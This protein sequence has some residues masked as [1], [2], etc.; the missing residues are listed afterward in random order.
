M[1]RFTPEG[2]KPT[3]EREEV[4]KLSLQ[5]TLDPNSFD[6][7]NLDE[8]EMN[9]SYYSVPFARSEVHQDNLLQ[10]TI[11]ELG[12]GFAQGFTANLIPDSVL[13]TPERGDNVANI[14]RQLGSLAGFM[15]Y[16]PGGKYI[17]ILNKLRGASLPLKAAT[18][19]Q[20]A[21]SKVANPF[22]RQASKETRDFLSGNVIADVSAG[23]FQMGVA[24]A[25]SG[26]WTEGVTTILK[27]AGYGAMYGGVARGIGNMTG[28]GKKIQVNQLNAATG[29]PQLSKLADGQKFDL[30][31]R[32]LAN[33]TF[34]ALSARM[35][36][37]TTPEQV[38]NFVM[39]GFLGWKDLPFS[40][41][42][43]QEFIWK[44]IQ[45]KNIE[46]P[47]LHPE[48]DLHSKEMQSVIKKD[49]EAYF[50]PKESIS[51]IAKLIYASGKDG[52]GILSEEDFF[53]SIGKKFGVDF[54]VGPDGVP[55]QKITKEMVK[56]YVNDYT[57]NGSYKDDDDLDMHIADIENLVGGGDRVVSWVGQTFKPP[58]ELEKINISADLYRMWTDNYESGTDG[59]RPKIGA[60]NAIY[61]HIRS[62]YNIKLDEEGKGWWRRLGEEQRSRV[63]VPQLT[64][65]NGKPSFLGGNVNALGNKKD[66]HFQRPIIGDILFKQYEKAGDK[67]FFTYLDHV[68]YEGKE[69]KLTEMEDAIFR[70]L[71]NKDEENLLATKELRENASFIH[72]KNLKN[73]EEYM[74]SQ[75]YYFVG[76][77][78]DKNAMY[79]VQKHPFIT[80]NKNSSGI[81]TRQVLRALREAYTN[82]NGVLKTKDL[83]DFIAKYTDNSRISKES[84]ASNILYDLT[85]NGFDVRE[86]GKG[87]NTFS[88]D[89]RE[90]LKQMQQSDFLDSP[91]KYNKRA[92]IWFNTGISADANNVSSL[93]T[94]VKAVNGNLRYKIFNDDK[95]KNLEGRGDTQEEFSDGAILGLKD[96][97]KALNLDKGMP[98]SGNVNKS[99]IV[100][101]N[102]KEG[103][104]LGK[105]MIHEPSAKKSAEME[106]DGVHFLMPK[107]AV[108]QM[109]LREF[110]KIYELPIE[111]LR[112]TMS[113][114]T[115]SKFIKPQNLPKQMMT[116]LSAFD[117]G[118]DNSALFKKMYDEFSGQGSIGTETGIKIA[119]D[120]L[121]DNSDLNTNRLLDNI[122]EVPIPTLFKIIRNPAQ[123]KASAGIMKKILKINDEFYRNSAEESE[124]SRGE[125][126]K[127]RLVAVEFDTIIDRII[128]IYPK[129]STGSF[130]HKFI[131][132]FR[133]VA[134]RNYAVHTYTRPKLKGSVVARI[135]P[136]D[137]GMKGKLDDIN[138][139]SKQI[140]YL[141]NGFKKTKIYDDRFENGVITLENLLKKT[142][143]TTIDKD[144]LKDYEE[145]IRAVTMRVPMDSIS[146]ANVLKLAGFT[147]IDGYGVLMHPRVMRALGGADLDGDKAFVFFG[148]KGGMKKEYK[149]MY[150]DARDEFFIKGEEQHNKNKED[151]L[152]GK[153]LRELFTNTDKDFLKEAEDPVNYFTSKWR[154][155]MSSSASKGRDILGVAVNNR[156]AILGSYNAIVK[157]GEGRTSK[158]PT[159]INRL[160]EDGTK[161]KVRIYEDS[162][163]N[164]IYELPYREL[165]DKRDKKT[166][167]I[168]EFSLDKRLTLKIDRSNKNAMQS[169]KERS[170]T[171]IAIGSDPM[172]ESGVKSSS[173][174]K[175]ILLE[176]LFEKKIE[177]KRNG[178]WV[179]ESKESNYAELIKKT[180][181]GDFLAVNS[182]LYGKNYETGKRHSYAEIQGTLS[183]LTKLP[184][185]ADN[186]VMVN[187]SKDISKINWSDNL[188]RRINFSSLNRMYE[189]H[190]DH[191]NG[192]KKEYQWLK[193]I[194]DRTSFSVTD[195]KLQ[196][197]VHNTNMW[198]S[199]AVKKYLKNDE[200]WYELYTNAP[201]K[202]NSI[203]NEENDNVPF[204]LSQNE[205]YSRELLINDSRIDEIKALSPEWRNSWIDYMVLKSEDMLVN[206]M[207][208]IATI[209]RILDIVKGKPILDSR[210]NQIFTRAKFIKDQS[211]HKQKERR[212]IDTEREFT[213]E[214]TRT[215]NKDISS[216]IDKV[217]AGADNVL[218]DKM[219]K[220][221]VKNENLNPLEKELFDTFLIGTLNKGDKKKLTKIRKMLNQEKNL[222]YKSKNSR[223]R[224]EWLEDVESILMKEAN[225]TSLMKV[226]LNSKAVDNINIK[227]F[228]DKY[229]SLYKKNNKELS[230]SE[231][232]DIENS[233][234]PPRGSDKI[235]SLLTAD[236]K[237][238]EGSI[239]EESDLSAV[240]RK[241]LDERAPFIGVTN[242]DLK[243]PDLIEAYHDITRHFDQ[244]HNRDAKNIN[245]LFR[246][247]TG[248]NVNVANKLDILAF[249]NYLDDMN[250][251]TFWRRSWDF[252]TG[253]NPNEIKRAYYMQFPATVSKELANSPAF[254][255]L[256]KDISPY[257]DHL[258]N[259]VMGTSLTPTTPM[260][261]IQQ[262]SAKSTEMSQQV[263]QDEKGKLR[264]EL[265]PYIDGIDSGREFYDIAVA[266]REKALAHKKYKDENIYLEEYI[267]NVKEVTPMWNRL[268]DKTF[269]VPLE[270]GVQIM[271]GRD[272]VS[273][274]NKILTAQNKRTHQWLV[275]DGET[276]DKW[277]KKAQDA[278]GE[279]NFKG[280]QILRK[281]WTQYVA[282]LLRKN[283]TIPIEKFGIDGIRNITK[284]IIQSHIPISFLKENNNLKK[285]ND[286]LGHESSDQTGKINFDEYFPHLGQDRKKV[287]ERYKH[288]LEKLK[289]E[290]LTEKE[291][292]IRI[293]QLWTGH[294]KLT[295]D[296]LSK[297]EMGENFDR[298]EDMITALSVQNKK[299]AERIMNSEL[300]KVGSQFS[301]ESH[302]G[303]WS[304]TPEAYD[305]YMKN[306][307]DTFYRQVMQTANRSVIHEFGDKFYRK[308]K[309]AK[310]TTAWRQFFQLYA[311]QAMGYPAHI[312]QKVMD[313]PL[314]KLSWTP[315][316]FMSDS[317]TKSRIDFIRKKLGIDR[318]ILS[319]YNISEDVIDEMTGVNY[320]QL[321]SY[322]AMEA[323][324]Q[325]ASLL[326]HP[327]SA[328]ANLYGGTIHTVIN[329]G[330]STFKNARSIEYLKAKVNTKWNSMADVE[331]WLQK[332]GVTEDFLMYEAGLNPNEKSSGLSRMAKDV[333]DAI[334]SGDSP[335]IKRLNEIRKKNNLSASAFKFAASFMRVPERALRRDAFMAHY[336]QARERF[337]NAIKDYD[338]P[339]LIEMAKKGVKA[340]QFLYSAP[341]RP[342]WTTSA[343][344]KIFSRF[345][346]WSWN[347]VRFRRDTLKRAKIYGF[348][349]GTD[350]HN[351]AVRMIQ[352]DA[353]MLGMASV[354]TYSLFESALPAP[355]NWLQDS[356]DYFFGDEKAKDRAFF[357]SPFGPFQIVTPPFMRALPQLFKWMMNK[358]EE[359][360][361]EYVAWSLFP[362]G[363]IGRDIFG[364]GGIIENP[365]YAITK[366]S[367]VPLIPMSADFKK[368]LPKTKKEDDGS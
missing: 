141:D 18:T 341:Y 340:T 203:S 31:M 358:E 296:Y 33:G 343:M 230:D 357:G 322:A 258:G 305:S 148:G 333:S 262:L 174:F 314:M 65:V 198:S 48:W 42:T 306:I 87:K 270:N 125:L 354:Y 114:I 210:I 265:L 167:K 241:Y 147:G 40:T 342:A 116:V 35:Q 355:Y 100:S 92:Q 327:K 345:Q 301:R 126:A 274:I 192:N 127:E 157:M 326:A 136:W 356:A 138:D 182:A 224:I 308:T 325:L 310:L 28:L 294:K 170:R 338:H 320:S 253:K 55:V 9:A 311:N 25:V 281:D 164:I 317:K 36:G 144:D 193:R 276:A 324:W 121:K 196:K 207:S 99:F 246:G 218:I 237:R 149:K 50:G 104:L 303:G 223:S 323:K 93:L 302:I 26:E 96:V 72:N 124:L 169:F 298:V 300:V 328:V 362:F 107:S 273:N 290:E 339:Y 67:N 194:L 186:N 267:N 165:V 95:N 214:G 97:I 8:L 257:K 168:N 234:S 264:D 105:Y 113:E 212:L 123:E 71:Q 83:N 190:K 232:R 134:L 80:S 316:K 360:I 179:K 259:T 3:K 283:E 260:G 205:T 69:Y 329:T 292:N 20:K 184:K 161:G 156:S 289:T 160:L 27:N 140:F 315:Y 255:Q 131:R 256:E 185:E 304:R 39:G 146:G 54:D 23:A 21:V 154:G 197:Y 52:K 79:Y 145:M 46:E 351:N 43:S 288:A 112:T 129:G 243:D 240:D 53:K 155:R 143:D 159:I 44:T 172:D 361:T 335:S 331:S 279:I 313:D 280:L 51:V 102:S 344:G 180:L 122:Q 30:S 63:F 285:I 158:N 41:R 106:K 11:G 120:F 162:K 287:K 94:K 275:G 84:M 133:M 14:S 309:D 17:G 85:W 299:R 332:L 291:R 239:I 211:Y 150:Q 350:A 16:I 261:K 215:L 229:D 200:A 108:K 336:L 363:R 139:D 319:E 346:L 277:I 286:K 334:A 189:E 188:Y 173:E 263:M 271:K 1:A 252:L 88:T 24:S 231:I 111:H 59:I 175:K 37:Q 61:R 228:F 187:L 268:K 6:E 90:K 91:K 269:R 76:G 213:D 220:D 183:R 245:W 249:R 29:A 32:V 216:V 227:K 7:D 365:Y 201:K 284:Y 235:T 248:K 19:A 321:D 103:A 278:K 353:F 295:G 110:D 307:I 272:I 45:D 62:K 206:D 117:S 101:P 347:S 266:M 177:T 137:D 38:Y 367:G 56:D 244:M 15:G 366:M 293:K 64:M 49:M 208:D 337:G 178:K 202:K 98:T 74:D 242:G 225:D 73:L 166:G 233:I 82:V 22:I 60:E 115:S 195:G 89:L 251:P 204:H 330:W 364:K 153:P 368:I 226:G 81:G 130:M 57:K 34:D 221:F 254:R 349:P 152:T 135:R 217:S 199:N 222:K 118:N 2:F 109:G 142:K 151:I 181:I 10:R 297:D 77:K 191:L 119:D 219:I 66:V 312:P 209:S 359:L 13:G 282:D 352:A 12:K 318:K 238:V 47:E 86:L 247:V 171:A 132:D 163:K 236:G 176:P 68:V 348:V 4:S 78:G 75:G 58:S 250:T 70:D 128:K 5:Y